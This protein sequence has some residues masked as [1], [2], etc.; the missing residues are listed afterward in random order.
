VRL[1]LYDNNEGY[2]LFSDMA[3][4]KNIVAQKILEILF[5]NDIKRLEIDIEV[6]LSENTQKGRK[7]L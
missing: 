1:T 5:E 4:D 7:K 2:D 6:T 3:S